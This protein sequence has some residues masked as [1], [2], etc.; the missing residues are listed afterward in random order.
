LWDLR[1]PGNTDPFVLDGHRNEI[2]SMAFSPDGWWLV[3]GSLDHTARLWDLADPTADPVVLSGHAHEIR[4][5]T[6]S[7]DGQWIVSGSAD[8]TTRLW[9]LARPNDAPVVLP[10]HTDDVTQVTISPDGQWLITGSVDGTARLWNLD[11][12]VLMAEACAKVGRN[13]TADEWDQF[14]GEGVAYRRTCSDYPIHPTVLEATRNLA[15][16]G[17]VE[18]AVAQFE[19]LLS[20][21]PTLNFDPETEAQQAYQDEVDT[22]LAYGKFYAR[23]GYLA[24]S[25]IKFQKALELNPDLPFADPLAET[26][27]L[28]RDTAANRIEEG[29]EL[30][31]NGKLNDA[32]IKFSETQQLE[33]N[34]Q[35][36]AKAWHALC[37]QGGQWNK[38][39]L[40][41]DACNRAV[42][43]EPENGQF[44]NSR[45]MAYLLLGRHDEARQDFRAFEEWLAK[46]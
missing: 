24:Q 35:I 8:H 32:L 6:I 30:A 40:V 14:L 36:P 37:S 4:A 20:L 46:Q 44:Y 1:N 41:L 11:L 27:R 38:P 7:P 29:I 3:T 9:T 31:Q 22:L 34:Y 43:L 42:E 2:T 28:A 17:Q 45:G 39:D 12:D 16:A 21:D 13:L 26:E 10:G 25:V 18:A 19:H 23:E 33:A 15:R 5:V